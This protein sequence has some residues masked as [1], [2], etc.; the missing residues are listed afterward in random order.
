MVKGIGKE[1]T[2]DMKK[3]QKEE[4]FI[5]LI[6]LRDFMFTHDENT[7]CTERE[8]AARIVNNM[9]MS[10]SL[11]DRG[12]HKYVSVLGLRECGV[13]NEGCQEDLICSADTYRSKVKKVIVRE[14]A[15][16]RWEWWGV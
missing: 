14:F 5:H 9:I 16:G 6:D 10:L 2:I 13:S 15:D 4:L 8:L 12:K 1:R 11:N 3:A 7:W